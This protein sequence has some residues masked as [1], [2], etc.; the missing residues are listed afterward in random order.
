[1]KAAGEGYQ[2]IA[3]HRLLGQ[4]QQ[5]RLGAIDIDVELRVVARLLD[6]QVDG[7]GDAVKFLQQIVG[8]RAVALNIEADDLHVDRRGQAEIQYLAD[9]VRRQEGERR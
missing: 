1:M 3:R 7:A 5:L 8:E 6:A 2:H 4:P 9:H